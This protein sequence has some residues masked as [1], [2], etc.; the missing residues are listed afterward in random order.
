MQA[1]GA[2]AF[3]VRPVFGG[4]RLPK[5]LET[6]PGFNVFPYLKPMLGQNTCRAV[7]GVAAR[8]ENLLKT[9]GSAISKR[10]HTGAS[11]EPAASQKPI[12]PSGASPDR[13]TR[14]TP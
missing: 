8:G 5:G 4:A 2:V 10:S 13:R 14:L 3:G 6:Q 12:R 9:H 7:P 1:G 11:F